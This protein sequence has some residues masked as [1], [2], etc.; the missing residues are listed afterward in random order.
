MQIETRYF[1]AA[2]IYALLGMLVGIHMGMSGDH[3]LAPAH[4]HWLLLG[5]VSLFLAGVFF[6]L[7]PA[8]QGRLAAAHWWIANLGVVVLAPGIGF[9]M[10]GRDS[11]GTPM[12]SAGSLIVLA[13]MAVFAWLVFRGTREA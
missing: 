4:A 2:A 5:W 6:R 3:R 9:I 13:G 8:V 7:Y 11:I 10:L 12:A 1:R